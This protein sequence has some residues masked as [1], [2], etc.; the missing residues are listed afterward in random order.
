[1]IEAKRADNVILADH[2][3]RIAVVEVKVEDLRDTSRWTM[4]GAL[5]TAISAIGILVELILHGGH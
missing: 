5:V 1:M 2:E 4:R 3:T